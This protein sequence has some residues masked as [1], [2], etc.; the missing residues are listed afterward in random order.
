MGENRQAGRSASRRSRRR[1]AACGTTGTPGKARLITQSC[2]PQV[3]RSLA[4]TSERRPPARSALTGTRPTASRAKRAESPSGIRS[5]MPGGSGCGWEGSRPASFGAPDAWPLAQ[6]PLQEIDAQAR[7]AAGRASRVR[8]AQRRRAPLPP[9]ALRALGA[10][11][12]AKAPVPGARDELSARRAGS[13]RPDTGGGAI[14]DGSASGASIP[15][16]PASAARCPKGGAGNSGAM[17][18]CELPAEPG[19]SPG[20]PEAG[21]GPAARHRRGP[22][23]GEP[24]AGRDGRARGACGD[25]PSG[26]GEPCAG[27]AA[28]GSSRPRPANRRRV[29]AT[30]D[31]ARR[32]E[33]EAATLAR[34]AWPSR[35]A[36]AEATPELMAVMADDRMGP[37]AGFDG[38]RTVPGGFEAA[39]GV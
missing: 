26:G 19:L 8:V 21:D 13:R 11:A 3:A 32:R 31:G 9:R 35:E 17:F 10:E 38:E 1:P 6:R 37:C 20:R 39:A 33:G 4:A 5:R 24:A 36:R 34:A 2:R 18:L 30:P 14:E 15:A 28:A 12:C 25:T 16:T 27:P 7:Q 23:S 22:P 29:A